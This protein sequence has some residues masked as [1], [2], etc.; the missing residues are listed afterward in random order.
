MS[1]SLNPHILLLLQ[2]YLLFLWKSRARNSDNTPYLLLASASAF[3]RG[4]LVYGGVVSQAC[5][6]F[7][8]AS[9]DF[10]REVP[11]EHTKFQSELYGV[12]ILEVPHTIS[13]AGS[14]VWV[15]QNR[16]KSDWLCLL[17]LT[18]GFRCCTTINGLSCIHLQG[19]RKPHCTFFLK[20]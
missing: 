19:A 8:T 12:L 18:S 14:L 1:K 2:T 15:T 6:F 7:I 10:P 5:P 9:Y 20:T 13:L 11:R 4:S 17:F 16:A 3:P